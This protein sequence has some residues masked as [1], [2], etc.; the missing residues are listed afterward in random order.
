ME[1]QVHFNY[2]WSKLQGDDFRRA[3]REFLD[4]GADHF[5]MEGRMSDQ[6]ARDPERRAFLHRVCREMGVHFSAVHG[7]DGDAFDLNIPTMERRPGMFR[8]HVAAMRAAAEFGCRTYVVHVGASFYTYKHVPLETLRPLAVDALEHLVPE[9]E[10]LGIVVAVENSFEKPNSAKELLKIVEPFRGSP[11]IGV[12]YDTGHAN[13]MASAPGK[14]KEKYEPYFPVCWWEDGVIWEDDAIDMLKDLVVTCHIH[15]NNGYG[16]L[17]G[18]PFDGTINWTDL[19][20]KLFAC[21]NMRDFQS[22]VSFRDG[23]GWA[24]KLLAP[25]GGYSIRRLTETFRKLGFR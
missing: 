15:D 13:C 3:V 18:M 14:Q 17:H 6:I 23:V 5:A 12:C 11:A 22:E 24:G 10:K 21:P 2:F 25:P 4:N 20:K 8:D 9:A 1:R 16:D 7:M 19:M